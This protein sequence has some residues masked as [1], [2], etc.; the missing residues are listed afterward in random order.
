MVLTG[1]EPDG[2]AARHF[3]RAI[4]DEI[5]ARPFE[6]EVELE[7]GVAMSRVAILAGVVIPERTFVP[8]REAMALAERGLRR[9][10]GL[11]RSAESAS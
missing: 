3:H 9:D 1:E 4:A 11:R 8:G 6:H 10:R 7:L 2:A 5:E